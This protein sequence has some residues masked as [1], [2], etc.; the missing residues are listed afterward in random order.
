MNPIKD[1]DFSLSYFALFAD[2]NTPTRPLN[3]AFGF[4]AA[5]TPFSNNGNFRGHYLQSI[6]KYKFTK[7]LSGLLLGEF[8]SRATTTPAM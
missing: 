2:Q 8:S 4:P 6:I 3:Q 7:H 5:A 1:M